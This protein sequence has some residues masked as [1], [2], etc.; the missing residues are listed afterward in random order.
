MTILS[1]TVTP[2]TA[3]L[4]NTVTLT[5]EVS[6]TIS[7]SHLA[8]W[9]IDFDETTDSSTTLWE[10]MNQDRVINYEW[11]P[12]ASKMNMSSEVQINENM[13]GE[14]TLTFIL[15]QGGSTG[16]SIADNPELFTIGD[17]INVSFKMHLYDKVKKLGN[18]W[19]Y[20]KDE[21]SALFIQKSN[22]VGFVKNDGSIE[23]IT[24]ESIGLFDALDC[25]NNILY[26]PP[27]NG[28]EAVYTIPYNGDGTSINFQPTIS[29]N[30]LQD[31]AGYLSDGWDNTV[32][33]ELTFE[34]YTTGDNNGYTVIPLGADKRDYNG[35]QQ[36]YNR[37]LNF[38]VEGAKPSGYLS[39]AG[40]R[41]ETWMSVK[42]TKEEYIWK[43][44]YD[45]VLKTT[46]DLSSYAAIVDDWTRMCIGVDRNGNRYSA[47]IRNI[48]VREI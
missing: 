38:Y 20:L 36:W 6:K 7:I 15:D 48:F 31:G 12:F 11:S 24:I 44:Y 45:D 25:I 28:T 3:Y 26:A 16:I 8:M 30:Q 1:T 10:L 39:N 21:I 33:W 34:Y 14:H 17:P 18:Q 43:V 22:T 13:L 5:S 2:T 35:I 47:A 32:N 9:I 41:L 29:N 19:F 23:S 40:L 46:F 27:L 37:Q 4:G 42:I